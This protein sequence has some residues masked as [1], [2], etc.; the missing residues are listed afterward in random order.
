MTG[1]AVAEPWLTP[2]E[3]TDETL[4][5]RVATGDLAAFSLLYDRYERPVYTMAAH[6][7]GAA[8]A[9]D[10]VQEA[11]LRLW[12]GSAQF[13]ES[14]GRFA[15]WFLS[16]T[17]HEI[18]AR[19]RRRTREQRLA[20]AEDIDRIL[21]ATPDPATDIEE[22]VWRRERGDLVLRA[23]N[24]L[25]SEQRR[26]LVLSYFGE[27]S[28][29]AIAESLGWPLGTVKKRIRLGLQKLR[30]ALALPDG[31]AMGNGRTLPHGE[32]NPTKSH[33]RISVEDGP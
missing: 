32:G 5:A 11:F 29:A 33:D 23:L 7:L 9:D 31:A 4:A 17:R 6:L 22:Q 25:P 14:R 2:P 20:L 30:R 19:L 18:L 27:L 15:P 26:V 28:Q 3:P 21:A 24:V 1:A 13:D 12:R 8:E 16:I 10:V